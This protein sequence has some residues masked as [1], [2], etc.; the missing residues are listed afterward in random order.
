MTP[1]WAWVA[2]GGLVVLISIVL[3]FAAWI[4]DESRGA[5]YAAWHRPVAA[6]VAVFG[7]GC[8][9]VGAWTAALA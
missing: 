6:S 4:A 8:I 9:I 5:D 3:V 2:T 7:I 1:A